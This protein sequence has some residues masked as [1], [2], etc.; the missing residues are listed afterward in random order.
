MSDFSYLLYSLGLSEELIIMLADFFYFLVVLAAAILCVLVAFFGYQIFFATRTLNGALISGVLGYL[1]IGQTVEFF[2]YEPTVNIKA[3]IG[4]IFA[5]LGAFLIHHFYIFFDFLCGGIVGYLL[6]N[7]VILGLLRMFF[8]Y[9][10]DKTP[11]IWVNAL[12]ALIFATVF[13]FF[14]KHIYIALTSFCGMLT[15]TYILG[16]LVLPV[17]NTNYVAILV[18]LGITG[19]FLG[20]IYQFYVSGKNCFDV[21]V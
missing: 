2:V 19:G 7:Y 8:P 10:Y 3:I 11:T 6:G 13:M 5:A 18:V 4:L 12:T 16:V 21:F 15:A 20:T 9:F 17:Y 1:F 14:F